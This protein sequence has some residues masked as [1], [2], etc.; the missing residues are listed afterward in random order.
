MESDREPLL[1]GAVPALRVRGR[2]ALWLL[3]AVALLTATALNWSPTTTTASRL[4]ALE[5]EIDKLRREWA[6]RGVSVAI[7]RRD[8]VLLARG[9]GE[10]N[11]RGEPVS[12]DTIFG[13]ASMTKAFTSLLVGQLV[14]QGKLS[15]T[16]PVTTLSP[17]T[18]LDPIAVSQATLIDI[19]S[20][21]TG[22]PRHDALFTFCNT[23]QDAL[24]RIRGLEPTAPFRSKWQ[25]NNWMY[26]L[27]GDIVRNVTGSRDWAEALEAGI[28]RPLNMTSTVGRIR[29]LQLAPDHARSFDEEGNLLPLEE[30]LPMEACGA[31][32][33]SANDVTKWLRALLGRGTLSGTRLV[34]D[35]TFEQLTRPHKTKD[36]PRS[37]GS[38]YESYGL[39]W[40]IVNY[41]GHHSV[42]HG[43]SRKGYQNVLRFFPDDDLAFVVM[44]SSPNT[45]LVRILDEVIAE[46]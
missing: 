44:T 43:G 40:E 19:L 28:L 15:W 46:R 1:R 20:H 39:G 13:I 7:V 25:Y 36:V 9:F 30:H 32:S 26:E 35:T 6:V 45:A 3:L 27:A 5:G 29:E 41:R 4:H 23:A 33:T 14:E 24:T 22:L 42:W 34:S 38:G 8:E 10:R 17:T 21:Q 18:F 11:E 12:A 16:T 31:M 37:E 2:L